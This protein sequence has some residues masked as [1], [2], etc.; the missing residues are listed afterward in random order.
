M[1]KFRLNQ[2]YFFN[3]NRIWNNCKATEVVSM[4]SVSLFMPLLS[5]SGLTS[6]FSSK[7]QDKTFRGRLFGKKRLE[8]ITLIRAPTRSIW[9]SPLAVWAAPC[10]RTL[11]GWGGT[12]SHTGSPRT[13]RHGVQGL[14][15][16]R[17][18]PWWGPGPGDR[19]GPDGGLWCAR[20]CLDGPR[21]R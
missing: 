18:T 9:W 17:S 6:S 2:N 5:Y 16:R 20:T 19:W 11:T 3:K 21:D 10:E 7:L 14:L 8:I 13:C 4:S 1:R 12:E 15:W